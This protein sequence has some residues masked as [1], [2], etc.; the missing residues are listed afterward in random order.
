VTVD[1]TTVILPGTMGA[2][3]ASY[4]Q[5]G[6]LAQG[7]NQSGLV[8][9]WRIFNADDYWRFAIAPGYQYLWN[10]VAANAR[11]FAANLQLATVANPAAVAPFTGSNFP[12]SLLTDTVNV[13]QANNWNYGGIYTGWGGCTNTWWPGFYQVYSDL[14][15]HFSST[16]VDVTNL[17]RPWVANHD[18]NGVLGVSVPDVAGAY[19][20]KATSVALLID[21]DQQSGVPTLV[22]PADGAT[23]TSTT[24]PLQVNA[25]TDPDPSQT[26]EYYN[27]SVFAGQPAGLGDDPANGCRSNTAI[28]SSNYSDATTSWNVPDGVLSDGVTYWWSVA[29][30]GVDPSVGTLP[31]AV[32]S[33]S[34]PWKFK[35]DRRLGASGVSPMETVGPF[36][37]NL[38]NGRVRWSV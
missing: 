13:C 17:L 9:N 19:T 10:S 2:T 33:C 3:W 22:Q 38:A 1:P 36:S 29:A 28:W 12:T 25:V 6:N 14:G 35:V 11:V 15:P 37:V 24:P 26:H 34:G 18:P 31:K 27:V 7:T 21:W 5:A 4:N 23:V 20:F 30:I 16:Y 8:G 32:P